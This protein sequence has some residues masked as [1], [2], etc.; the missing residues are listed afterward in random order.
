MNIIKR[1]SIHIVAITVV[2]VALSMTAT[3]SVAGLF[4]YTQGK[5]AKP[6]SDLYALGREALDK[7][8]GGISYFTDGEGHVV[9]VEAKAMANGDL[10][11]AT[12]H[13]D[14]PKETVALNQRQ[15]LDTEK[16]LRNL[17]ALAS[18]QPWVGGYA[19]LPHTAGSEA[20][21]LGVTV[22]SELRH[23]EGGA[24]HNGRTQCCNGL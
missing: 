7:G 24:Y 1:L 19:V 4:D 18:Q 20:Y 6:G 12:H 8:L 9:K 15:T 3:P 13:T 5:V 21:K 17:E 14:I 11:V 23:R 16:A 10:R 22:E 2:M